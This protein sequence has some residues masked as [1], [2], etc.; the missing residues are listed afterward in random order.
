MDYQRRFMSVMFPD[1]ISYLRIVSHLNEHQ[2]RAVALKIYTPQRLCLVSLY[3]KREQIDLSNIVFVEYT[4][5]CSGRRGNVMYFFIFAQKLFPF[6]NMI[7]FLRFR[8]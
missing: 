6:L 1:H 5:K 4:A 7:D 3:V 2:F 8:V